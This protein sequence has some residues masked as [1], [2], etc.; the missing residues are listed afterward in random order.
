MQGRATG[1]VATGDK[2]HTT[3]ASLQKLRKV[4]TRFCIDISASDLFEIHFVIV[5]L[6]MR[7]LQEGITRF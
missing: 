5:A 7:R 1:A 2:F 3:G 6:G 4:I